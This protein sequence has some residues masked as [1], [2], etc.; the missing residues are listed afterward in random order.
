MAVVTTYGLVD[1]Y[2]RRQPPP[3]EAPGIANPFFSD[4]SYPNR[5]PILDTE[6]LGKVDVTNNL[7]I[8]LEPKAAS[9]AWRMPT[10][11]DD[12]YYRV[13]V[14]PGVI[15]LGNLL[16]TQVRDVEVWSA[17]FEPQL[18]SSLSQ[19]GTDGITLTQ[20]QVPPTFFAALEARIYTLNI[21]TNGAPVINALYTFNFPTD[22]PTLTVTGR[23][24]VVWPFMPQTKHKE[25]LEWQ[26]DIIPSFNNEQ[27]LALRPA[28]RQSFSHEFQLDTYQF[29]RAKAIATQWAHRVYGIPVWSELT[30]LGPLSAGATEVL[31]DTTVADYRQDDIIIIW[32]SDTNNVAVEIGAVLPDRV[33]LKLPLEK[34]YQ[35][36]YVA[37]LRFARTFDGMQF[38]RSNHDFTIASATFQV[39][40]N[41]DL[42][43]AVGYP[44]YRGKDVLIDPT[45]LVS[46]LNE[47]ISRATDEFDNGS[48]PIV[49]DIKNNWVNSAKAITFDVLTRAE[50]WAARQWI[51]SRRG[52]QKGFWL[53][54]WN[55]DL[56]LLEDVG[57][58]GAALTVRPI[59]YPLY[60]GVKDIMVQL[61]NGTRI[62]ARVLSGAV[63]PN[64]NEVLSLEAAVGTG[65]TVAEVDFICFM[66]HVRFNSDRVEIRHDY[67][68][69]AVTTIPVVETP[70]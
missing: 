21:S 30:R 29:S 6:A 20:P 59:G 9:V 54:T 49:V 60:Y 66:S 67:A 24:V 69:R 41:K 26:T 5:W 14:R 22:H 37:P 52:R 2:M 10:F 13:H 48:G 16:S 57:P 51:H 18:L 12:Y 8:D 33:Q 63:D 15:E 65:F 53:P 61:K 11:L 28:P 27:R 32:E 1:F 40:Q 34:S 43:A 36:A 7:P 58:T 25:M 44:Q 70:E 55:P 38:R 46:D 45:I 23:R 62:F 42:G 47:R 56:I 68:G 4:R 19:V 50:R 17:Y 64:G 39:T 3:Q 35:N 31:V